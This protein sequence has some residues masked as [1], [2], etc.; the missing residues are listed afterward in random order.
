MCGR[1]TLTS[2]ADTLERRFGFAAEQSAAPITPRFNICPGQLAPVIALDGASRGLRLMRWGLVPHWA[3]DEGIGYKMINARAETI[4]EKPSF[5]KPFREKR[6][7]VLADGF[8]EWGQSEK[9]I[10]TPLRFTLKTKEPFALAG[11]WDLWHKPDGAALLTFTIITTE[12]N[13]LMRPIHDRMPVILAKEDESF[14]L[15]GSPRDTER[16]REMLAPYPSEL[17]HRCEVSSLVNSPKNDS[18]LCIE[19]I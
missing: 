9:K 16:L 4:T 6:C 12:A 2:D 1:Y 10:K 11:L 13:A 14:W 7:L 18:P 15:G 8:Y 17:M 3:G 5:R 19:P